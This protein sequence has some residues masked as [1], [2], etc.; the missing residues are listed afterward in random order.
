MEGHTEKRAAVLKLRLEPEL[1]EKIDVL[2]KRQRKATAQMLRETLW[3]I[4]EEDEKTG[5]Q[6]I[7][8][9]NATI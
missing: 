6:E 1:K 8:P 2:A 9:L 7:L 3:R 5:G 4:V